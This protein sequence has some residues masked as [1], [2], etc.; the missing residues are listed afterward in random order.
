MRTGVQAG[1]EKRAIQWSTRSGEWPD[2]ILARQ[3]HGNNGNVTGYF[4]RVR[5]SSKP[6]TTSENW[7]FGTGQCSK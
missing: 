7:E 3:K 5:S 1:R 2:G 6:A 4:G